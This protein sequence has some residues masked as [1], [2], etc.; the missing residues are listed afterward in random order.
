MAGSK[1]FPGSRRGPAQIVALA[2]LG[3]L[4]VV[5]GT[6]GATDASLKKTLNTWSH[7]I[8]VDASGIGLSASR[9]HPRRMTRRARHFRADALRAR[10]ALAAQQPSSARGSRAK[11]LAVAAFW[12]YARVGREW[13][14]SGTAR[15]HHK[16][17][18][19]SRYATLALRF[20]RTGN[21]LLVSA[22][23]LLG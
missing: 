7:R 6:A 12:N 22:G 5:P 17:P 2:C 8:G 13:A 23:R 4:L 11:R 10:R 16:R 9:R 1:H 14:L 15:L 19:A 18:L 20:A 21:R 3:L